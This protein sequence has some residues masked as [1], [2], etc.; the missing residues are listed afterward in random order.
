MPIQKILFGSPGTGKSYRIKTA[1]AQQVH[2]DI[3]SPNY[4]STVFHPEYTYGDFIG[5]LVPLTRSGKV[6]YNFYTG[7][8]TKAIGKAYKNLIEA[9]IEYDKERKET[10][11]NYKKSISKTRQE[12]F[13][14]IEKEKLEEEYR[15]IKKQ[16]KNVILV[17]DELNRGNS[18]AIFGIVFQLLDRSQSG[19]SEY[20][21]M[22]SDIEKIGLFGEIGFEEYMK[23]DDKKYEY[24]GK[25]V[26]KTEFDKYQG[27]I[28][29]DLSP[30]EMITLEKNQIK[31]PPNLSIVAT[32]NTSDNS[33]YFMDNAFK[34]RWDWE[35]V[36]IEDDNQRNV[37]ETRRINLYE[38][39]TCAWND[40]VD[41]LNAFI[42]SHYK[43]VRKI[44]DK[45]IG[46][47][48]INEQEINHE[49]IKNKLMFFVWDS[50]FNTNR[51]PLTDLLE[52]HER[53]LV[54]FG[55]F[56]QQEVVKKFVQKII[57]FNVRP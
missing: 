15:K 17:I 45:Q 48:F 30:M 29:E 50:V 12:E 41:R 32:M 37:V 42:R 43:T 31:I 35:F 21:I 19:W 24:E 26:S 54:T 22:I 23:G 55:Q 8:F 33:I 4:I 27:W 10:L 49:H 18:A 46:Y 7:H 47:F 2:V 3:N 52:M 38:H 16:P 57:Q 56:T 53:D 1:I 39:D 11:E 51:K 13:S 5:K 9:K 6:E 36:N 34:R 14:E 44:E 40:F 20:P 25:N 28:F